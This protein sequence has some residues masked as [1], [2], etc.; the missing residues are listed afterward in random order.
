MSVST[1]FVC[2]CEKGVKIA[3]VFLPVAE[4]KRIIRRDMFLQTKTDRKK[5]KSEK[6]FLSKFAEN[7][8]FSFIPLEKNI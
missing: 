7:K 1:G 6:L 3:C 4:K 5:A 2:L 8:L